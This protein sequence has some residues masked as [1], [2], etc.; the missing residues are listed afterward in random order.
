MTLESQNTKKR[1]LLVENIHPGAAEAFK[2]QGHE[3]MTLSYAPSETELSE[4][5]KDIDFIGIRS[6]TK[7]TEK[8]FLMELKKDNGR[9][10]LQMV[11]SQKVIMLMGKKMQPGPVGGISIEQEK[12]C[13]AHIEKV[14]W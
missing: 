4:L 5:L 2:K 8:V 1:I 10:G 6:K 12:K 7:M 3:V 13:K 14:K 9:L 11:A